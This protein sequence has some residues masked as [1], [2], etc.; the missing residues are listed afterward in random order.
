MQLATEMAIAAVDEALSMLNH[1]LNQ[2]CPCAV[3][4]LL[5]EL[6]WMK[7]F[8]V[9]GQQTPAG[10]KR[11]DIWSPIIQRLALCAVNLQP[12]GGGVQL[13]KLRE[14]LL[15]F[16]ST[17]DEADSSSILSNVR[18]WPPSSTKEVIPKSIIKVTAWGGP[19]GTY[20]DYTF[21]GC[22]LKQITIVNGEVV[23]SLSFI[24]LKPDGLVKTLQVGGRGGF[25]TR[26]VT[27]S[28][29]YRIP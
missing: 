11:A 27:T 19:G 10:K 5:I 8:L 24:S 9:D 26:E 12:A 4:D 16:H 21:D 15:P 3:D 2:Y 1:E 14:K 18:D 6:P 22:A 17:S 23:D 29:F 28:H 25:K 20:W 13:S 7:C